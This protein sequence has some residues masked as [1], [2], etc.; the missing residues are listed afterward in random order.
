MSY[1]KKI[2][3]LSNKVHP[4]SSGVDYL[5]KNIRFMMWGILSP[6]VIRAMD[7]LHEN[8]NLTTIFELN[9]KLFEKPLK[10]FISPRFS[11]KQRVNL[12][13]SH[14]DIL[15]SK[16]GKN[17]I[18]IYAQPF[19][20]TTF[21]DRNGSAYRI[22]LFSGEV[23]EGSIGIR[24]VECDTGYSIYSITF[25]LSE[26]SGERVLHI[27][28][29]QGSNR[30]VVDSNSKIKEITR[31]LHGL[32]P[33]ALMLNLSLSFARYFNVNKVV[34][35]SNKGH[36][37][38]ALRYW[39]SKKNAIKS[40]YD[41]LW[42]ENGGEQINKHFYQIPTNL[43]RKELAGLKRSKRSLYTKRYALLDDL[44]AD[45]ISSLNSLIQ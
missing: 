26:Q 2:Y 14:F 4:H 41:S 32:R 10:P 11:S 45:L 17:V 40:D 36:V 24:L 38:Q 13:Q 12:I 3:T 34:A 15:A 23:R 42:K 27:G 29:L 33:K 35:V 43:E 16:F 20:I 9:Y 44:E 19:E 21:I 18:N 7:N 25:N 31:T 8:E 28:C 39:G 30:H 37:Y 5:R 22:E 1:L 6:H